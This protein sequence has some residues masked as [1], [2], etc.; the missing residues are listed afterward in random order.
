[1]NL[2]VIVFPCLMYL[3]SVSAYLSFP[4][5]VMLKAN[6]DKIAMGLLVVIS[7]LRSVVVP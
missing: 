3:S 6:V 4:R 2:W 5:T 1:M 7:S